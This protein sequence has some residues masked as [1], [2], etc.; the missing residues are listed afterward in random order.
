MIKVISLK[1]SIDRRNSFIKNNA[2]LNFEFFDAIDGLSLD[3][4]KIKE[5]DLFSSDLVY[6]KGAYGCALSHLYLWEETIK[7]NKPLTIVEDDAIFR[8][9]F[10]NMKNKIISQMDDNWDIILW[11]WNFDSILSLNI[12]P[13]VSPVVA[14]FEQNKLINSIEQFKIAKNTPNLIKLDKAFGLPAYTISPSG[15]K[16]FKE[17]C[18]PLTKFSLFFPILDRTLSNNGIDIATNAIYSKTNSFVSLPPLVVT[19]NDKS[20][21]TIQNKDFFK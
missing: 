13:D 14:L 20:I 2:N 7:N 16:K 21:S 18:F 5:L 9:D 8:N 12:M 1:R 15:A 10:D 19:K 3:L 6:T 11:G 4:N 17:L